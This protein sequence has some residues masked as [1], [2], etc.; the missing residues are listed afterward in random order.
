MFPWVYEFHWS[1]GHILFLTIFFSIITIVFTTLAR[2]LHRTYRDFTS[3]HAHHVAWEATFEELPAVSR[4]CRHTMNGEVRDRVCENGFDCRTCV[5]HPTFLAQHV[6]QM[7][8]LPSVDSSSGVAIP[9][10]RYYHRGH[11]WVKPD[12]FGTVVV[13]V[14]DIGER[15]LGS[16]RTPVLPQPGTVLHVGAPAIAFTT[17]QGT[18]RVVSPVDGVVIATGKDHSDWLLRLRPLGV[19]FDL[20]HLLRGSEVHAW[21][22]HELQRLQMTLSS[23]DL[24]ARLA[25]GGELMK[26]MPKASPGTDWS[27]VRG[28]MFLEP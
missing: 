12:R 9:Q 22:M 25:D 24:G 19:E 1:F 11:T 26:D 8:G 15:L 20:R 6:P 14:D 28:E 16:D 5:M 4:L 23:D 7:A 10:D 13:G 21:V 2:A 17:P 18:T 27:S 3:G